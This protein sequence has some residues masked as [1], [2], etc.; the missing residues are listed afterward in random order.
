M[1][2]QKKIIL[3]S[4]GDPSSIAPEITIKALQSKK[5]HEKILPIIVTDP[6]LIY[7]YSDIIDD[8]LKVNE[9]QDQINFTDYK[10][11]YFNVIP[12]KTNDIVRVGEPSIANCSFIKKSIIKCIKLEN[13][14][15]ASAIVTNPINKNIMYKSG[16]KYSGHTEFLASFSKENIQPVMM[17][18]GKNLKTIP[19]TIHVPLSQVSS[20]IT[21]ELIITTIKI[22]AKYLTSYFG[23]KKPKIIL[24]GLNP[25]SGENGDIGLKN[26][27]IIIP[28]IKKIQKNNDFLLDG[29]FS[30]DTVF[31]YEARQNYDV[32]ICMYHDQALIPI[33]TLDFYNGVNV[34]LGLDFIRTSPDHGTGF[35]IAGKNIANPSSLI[36]SAQMM[37]T[38]I[39]SKLFDHQL[40]TIKEILKKNNIKIH[41]SLGQNFLFDINLTDKIVK[42][43]EPISSTIIEIGPGP[44]GL[45][46]SILKKNPNILFAIDKDNQSELMLS[47]LKELYGDKLQVIIADAINY[48]IWNLGN[49]PRQVIANLPYNVGTK[50]LISWL[51][52]IKKFEK[53]TLM[54]QKEVADR[55]IAPVG[56]SNYGRLSILTN[57]LTKSKKLFDLPGSAFIPPPK[58]TSTVIELIPMENP[59]FDVSFNSLEKITQMTFSQRRKMLKSSLK[60]IN[61]EAILEDLNISSRLRPEEL[62][63]IDF[64]RIAK[65]A[66]P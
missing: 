10:T 18:V 33:K 39:M 37:L 34:T 55:I 20:L 58:V 27:N 9:I 3:I 40:P 64:C 28:A 44:G 17:L 43:S 45:T 57:W 60:K 48:P 4:S 53:L 30:A 16:F 24:T 46:R 61:G 12:V 65:K 22:T 29:P 47:D 66:Y 63:I 2:L 8:H 52:H 23:I 50:M 41:K 62:T 56:S 13:K 5:I 26:K 14:T 21:E 36:L 25:H 59:I 51:K 35:D 1:S 6:K 49:E 31:S 15:A 38:K 54:F 19:L 11:N 7:N 32:A 42:K